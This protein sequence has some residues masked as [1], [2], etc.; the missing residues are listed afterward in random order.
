MELLPHHLL[1]SGES[2]PEPAVRTLQA[3]P[4]EVDYVGGF[5]RYVRVGGHEIVRMINFAVR[6]RDWNT[7]PFR[8]VDEHIEEHAGCFSI[9]YRAEFN[10][11]SIRYVSDIRFEGGPDGSLLCAFNGNA[12]SSFERNRIG[13]TVLHPLKGCSGERID[14]VHTDGSGETGVFP[15]L[16]SGVQPF[17]DIAGFTWRT[18]NWTA[19]LRFEGDIFEM[20]DQR[21]WTDASFKTYCTPLSLPF[22]VAVNPGDQVR[23]RVAFELV[24]GP[25]GGRSGV[26]GGGEVALSLDSS[27]R[28]MPHLGVA[29]S[30]EVGSLT[31]KEV[32]VLRSLRFAHYRCELDFRSDEW[33]ARLTS[34]RREAEQIRSAL[35]LVLFLRDTADAEALVAA[36]ASNEGQVEVDR[37]VVLSSEHKTTPSELL[38]AVVE[39]L[40]RGFPRARIGAGTDAFFAE[41]NR[42]RVSTESVDFLNYSINPQVHAF[43]RLSLIESLEAQADTVASAKAFAGGA[44]VQVSPVTFRMRWNPNAT[45][46]SANAVDTLAD[47]DLR[48]LSLFGA[49]WTLGSLA[50]LAA[51]GAEAITFFET[52]GL[53]GLM[54]AQA[55]VAAEHFPAPAGVCYPLY[56]LFRELAGART[57]RSVHANAE[58]RVSALLLVNDGRL[59]LLLANLTQQALRVQLPEGFSTRRC[60]VLD[61]T[62]WARFALTPDAWDNASQPWAGSAVEL[63][64]FAL[65]AFD[66]TA[67]GTSQT[68]EATRSESA[69][70]TRS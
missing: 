20:E 19:R 12:L 29:R 54:Q 6:D 31:D 14:V 42:Q 5:L 47:V 65:T 57:F 25:T 28:T 67:R 18:A 8:I 38:A 52:I 32:T 22:P 56:F 68:S 36:F 23:Q 27:A 70:G 21:N 2:S 4:L 15:R 41:L 7:V 40:R 59:R 10:A 1:A 37:L 24:S 16:I 9:R 34:A 46:Q 39:V 53:R 13:F 44:G 43:D 35:E 45:S 58:R 66:G 51:A 30:Q 61:T 63:P 26:G 62:T 69:S 11:D 60:R 55:P 49:G 17:R 50:Q 3:G 33:R 48:Q 64:A